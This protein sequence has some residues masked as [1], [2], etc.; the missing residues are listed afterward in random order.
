MDGA[1]LPEPDDIGIKTLIAI[2]ALDH[3]FFGQGH[4]KD[5]QVAPI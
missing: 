2:N 5:Y 3:W 1:D 4:R